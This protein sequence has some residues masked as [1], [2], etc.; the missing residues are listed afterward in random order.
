MTDVITIYNLSVQLQYDVIKRESTNKRLQN[1]FGIY[2][3]KL[4]SVMRSTLNK[5]K[6]AE[7]FNQ[8][9]WSTHATEFDEM[10]SRQWRKLGGDGDE[11]LKEVQEMIR[12]LPL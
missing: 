9:F 5:F 6:K 10:V 3:D 12:S 8:S 4:I 1:L 11:R 7:I 2:F